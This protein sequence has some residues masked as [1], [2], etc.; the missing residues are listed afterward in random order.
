MENLNIQ[1]WVELSGFNQL[2]EVSNLGNFRNINT[3]KILK[4]SLSNSGYYHL[5]L[6]D[7]NSPYFYTTIQCHRIIAS[8]FLKSQESK[9]IVNH[10]NGIK[11]DNRV[12]NLEW[13]NQS[14]NV[15]HFFD[16][17]KENIRRNKFKKLSTK[18]VK[19][20]HSLLRKGFSTILIAK[21]FNVNR[22]TISNI[23]NK[24]T[25]KLIS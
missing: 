16:N 17:N 12:D 15:I 5:N 6:R 18:N 25:H 21:Q 8:S 22:T 7:T 1:T 2:Y 13:V 4:P 24:V 19:E 11:T 3:K 23:K 20:I 9:N 14:E 10:K